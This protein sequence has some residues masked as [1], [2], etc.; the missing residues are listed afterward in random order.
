MDGIDALVGGT[1]IVILS[2]LAVL[3]QDPL[4]FLLAASYAGFLV[5]NLP[6][7]RIFMGDAGSTVLGGLVAVALLSGR[8]HLGPRHLLLLG[9]L[10][11][12]S[13]YT[14]ARRLLRGENVTRAHHSHLYQR[15]IRAGHSHARVSAGY[16]IATLAMGL[17]MALGG[18]A[19]AGVGAVTCA[20]MIVLIERHLSRRAVPFTVD[21]KQER[22][23]ATARGV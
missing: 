8:D 13:V 21:G 14:I 3:I 6:P 22:A 10:I 2:F 7:A 1:G 12:D 23:P 20:F 11:G 15:L 18:N 16:L 4:W 5:F 9:P 17:L 19:G